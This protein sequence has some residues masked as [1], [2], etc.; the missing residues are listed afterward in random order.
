MSDN[1]SEGAAIEA[2]PVLGDDILSIA[3]LSYD[4]KLENIGD[5]DTFG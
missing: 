4:N 5:Q 2:L 3:R 1:G